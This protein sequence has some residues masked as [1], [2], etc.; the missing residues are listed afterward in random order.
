MWIREDCIKKLAI[1]L[2]IL[3][4]TRGSMSELRPRMVGRVS[5]RFWDVRNV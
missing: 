5:C 4:W 3:N 1:E 2:R